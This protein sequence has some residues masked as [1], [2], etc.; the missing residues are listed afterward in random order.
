MNPRFQPTQAPLDELIGKA[1]YNTHR[2]MKSGLYDEFWEAGGRGS[3]KSSFVAI[4]ILTG[5][6]QDKD[7]N[8]FATRKVG[9]TIADSIKASFAWAIQMLEW[10][11]WYHV[12]KALNTITYIPTGQQII[13]RGLDDPLK[14]KSI[15]PR[16][17]YFKFLWFEEG[18][19]Y[20]SLED[21]ESVTQSVLRGGPSF[22]QFV[23]YNPPVEP[24]HW[25]NVEAAE[26]KPRRHV[27]FSCYTDA[28]KQWLGPK[29]LAD[30]EEMKRK[31]P[32]K[33]ANIYLGKS[34]GRSEAIIFSGYYRID[35]FEVVKKMQRGGAPRYFIGT[36]EVEGPY[37]GADFGFSVD[38]STLVKCW[39]SIDGRRIYI[40]YAVFGRAIKNNAFPDF[41]S[42]VPGSK[43]SMIYADSARPE[44]IVHI[45]DLGYIISGA[46]KP[47]GS[48]EDGI[49]WLTD[50]EIIIHD[51]CEE[52][53]DE[54]VNYC[55][56]IDRQTKEVTADIID[57]HNHGWDAVRYAF[58]PLIIQEPKGILDVDLLAEGYTEQSYVSDA[59]E[60]EERPSD[61]FLE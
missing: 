4:K 17:G 26:Q 20:A 48:V 1:F 41:Y 25:I 32:D 60:P 22:Q 19:E 43:E 36:D 61:D 12:P 30:A 3:L 11:P 37:F 6:Q 42:Q 44:T 5:M 9:D 24:K 55:Y 13:M 50:H 56:K 34:V 21:M 8:A 49:E 14:I 18:A 47:K 27:N 51:R 33:Y 54:A 40:E 53:Q 39:R 29:F 57:K 16:K 35:K 28:P 7:A 2:A 23:T 45:A 52:L 58:Y 46:E 31:K 38:P 15:R 59:Q 10:Q